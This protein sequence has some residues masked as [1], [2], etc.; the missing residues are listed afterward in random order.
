MN[1]KTTYFCHK[2]TFIIEFLQENKTNKVPTKLLQNVLLVNGNSENLTPKTNFLNK[3]LYVEF[4]ASLYKQSKQPQK[5]NE[6]LNKILP[7]GLNGNTENFTFPMMK[8]ENSL[9]NQEEK[10]D[11]DGLSNS[12]ENLKGK[13]KKM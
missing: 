13:S 2:K 12:N 4:L 5:P 10:S 8:K 9:N 11:S 1:I 7:K 3:S 6:D